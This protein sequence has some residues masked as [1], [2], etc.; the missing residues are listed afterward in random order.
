MRAVGPILAR[1][2]ML[3]SGEIDAGLQGAPLNYMAID[4]GFPSLCE[5]R[6]EV[7]DFQ[8]TSLNVDNRWAAAN[9]ETMRKF[10]R[11]FV[12]AHEYF[13]A[14]PSGVTPIAIA[15]TGIT[16]DYARRAWKE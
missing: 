12:R 3:Q 2:E 1:W 14:N 15:E 6:H 5:P 10:M 16:G 7:P 11:A 4:Q 8:F 13:F 9:G